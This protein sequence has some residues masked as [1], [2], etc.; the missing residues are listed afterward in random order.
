MIAQFA[1]AGAI[2]VLFQGAVAFLSGAPVSP[3]L[4]VACGLAQLLVLGGMRLAIHA[5]LRAA[6][7]TGHN[8]RNVL[9]AGS[10]PRA[11]YVVV[12]PPVT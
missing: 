3:R 6:R 5:S 7:R 4:P 2:V 12:S 9:I 10:G 11:A 8:T 1:A